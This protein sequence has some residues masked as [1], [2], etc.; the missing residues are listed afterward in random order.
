MNHV[1]IVRSEGERMTDG[2]SGLGPNW[3]EKRGRMFPVRLAFV[4]RSRIRIE[5]D[6]RLRLRERD[7]C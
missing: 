5:Y 6:E 7:S 4:H 3:M 2:D 1:L